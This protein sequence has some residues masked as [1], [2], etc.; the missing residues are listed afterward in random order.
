MASKAR[1]KDS[2]EDR[3]FYLIV[4]VL[5]A[6]VLIIVL[7]PLIYVVSSS[8]SDGHAVRN[9]KVLLWPVGFS[10]D[11]YRTVFQF[12][13]VISGYLNSFKYM[14]V[15]TLVNVALTMVCAYPLASRTLP[16]RNGIMFLFSFTMY[17]GGGLIPS[18][19]MVRSLGM[20]NTMWAL[21]VPGAISVYNMIIT[22]TFIQN[23]IPVEMLE[24]SQIDGCNDLQFLVRMVLPLS[25]AILAVIT[26]Y[27]AVGHWNGWF[28]AFIYLNDRDL[29]PLQLILRDIL[30]VSSID[31][32]TI[33]D[34]D[35]IERLEYTR[36]LVK[37]ALIVVSSV[38]MMLLYPF[39]QKYFIRGV[40]IGSLKG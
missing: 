29:Y 34:P 26:L 6:L 9:G 38:P 35:L 20:L 28:D 13:T 40:M 18:Y 15:G 1:I 16:F 27:Y 2:R 7:Y 24:A 14:I 11:G 23:N 25:K 4:N 39:V 8:F 19:L 21:I 3:A 31:P 10:L 5:M 30:I 22:R 37:Y 17:F 12:D 32:T 36:D 33:D